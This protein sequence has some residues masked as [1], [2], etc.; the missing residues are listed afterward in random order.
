[1]RFI[2]LFRQT[3]LRSNRNSGKNGFEI[4][5]S[6]QI[7][8]ALALGCLVSLPGCG[9]CSNSKPATFR[10]EGP[11]NAGVAPGA[12]HVAPPAQP[13]A[14]APQAAGT[15]PEDPNTPPPT[16]DD[17]VVLPAK[18]EQWEIVGSVTELT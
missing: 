5:W 8:F 4:K 9:G 3:R 17:F 16:P 11:P 14:A 13:F 1:M 15:V 7:F 18:P 2:R 6:R 10:L 12:A